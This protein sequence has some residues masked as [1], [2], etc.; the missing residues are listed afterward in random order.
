MPYNFTLALIL[1]LLPFTSLA[2][3]IPNTIL[4][5][6]WNTEGLSTSLKEMLRADLEKQKSNIIASLGMSRLSESNDFVAENELAPKHTLNQKIRGGTFLKKGR[7][8]KF[9][10]AVYIQ[11]IFCQ[12]GKN[13]VIG[14][15]A[16][17]LID[18]SLLAASFQSVASIKQ[19]EGGQK[20]LT[21]AL[22]QGLLVSKSKSYLKSPP[23]SKRLTAKAPDDVSS[24][25]PQR[26]NV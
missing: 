25:P 21:P 26:R 8:A 3:N 12:A 1:L 17:K 15:E 9:E 14:I 24:S 6:E 5:G 16:A 13:L 10:D 23:P 19:E 2:Q 20:T 22:D 11:P 4:L 18:G 7:F